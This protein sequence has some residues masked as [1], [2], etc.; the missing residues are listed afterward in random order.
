MATVVVLAGV[1]MLL[2]AQLTLW[3]PQLPELSHTY[4]RNSAIASGTVFSAALALGVLVAGP[5]ADRYGR[6]PLLLVGLILL[7]AASLGAAIAPTWPLHLLARLAQGLAAA[8]Y[9][10]T[11]I[12]WVSEAL[13]SHQSQL[14]L[15]ILITAFQAATPVGQLYSQAITD[16]AGW[17]AVHPTLAAGYLLAALVLR[18]RLTD[19]PTSTYASVR[20]INRPAPWAATL[21]GLGRLLGQ[22]PLLA[23][24]LLSVALAGALVAMYT[25]LQTH[26]SDVAP[27]GDQLLVT[28]R[29]AGLAG[30]LAAPLVLTVLSRQRLWEQALVGAGI[31]AA[32]LFAQTTLNHPATLIPLVAC[33]ALVALSVAVTMTPVS[34]M[35]GDLAPNARASAV[36]AQSA[37]VFLGGAIGSSAA[38]H[39][40]YPM[41]CLAA[42][43]VVTMAA[44][45]IAATHNTSLIDPADHPVR[46]RIQ[47]YRQRHTRSGVERRGA[48]QG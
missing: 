38:T 39:L 21:P 1:G 18:R 31:A 6:R 43:A 35:A 41:V 36:A 5:L 9:P 3:I 44:T 13:P 2:L 12:A 24:L 47:P 7:A 19:T 25:G 10:A 42:A 11:A 17:R 32:A 23:C 46:G 34:A 40:S 15:A 26:L 14:G 4:G 8:S 16:L 27:A 37:A 33:S 20:G 22:P 28:L 29:V 30:T 48:R 45:T